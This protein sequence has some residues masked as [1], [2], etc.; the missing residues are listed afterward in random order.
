[1]VSMVRT[2]CVFEGVG[3]CAGR[4]LGRLVACRLT[5]FACLRVWVGLLAVV[6]VVEVVGFACWLTTFECSRVWV[7]VLAVV[8]VV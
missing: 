6:S 2:M 1:M 7:G 3:G 5:T 8:G 4:R